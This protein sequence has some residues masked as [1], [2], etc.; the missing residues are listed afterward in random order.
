MR[1]TLVKFY[2]C[3]QDVQGVGTQEDQGISNDD[4][5][6]SD[7]F[8]TF[9]LDGAQVEGEAIV[10][11]IAGG[12]INDTF[13]VSVS[14]PFPREAINEAVEKCFRLCVGGN[15]AM[16]DITG[17]TN[18]RMSNNRFDMEY[19]VELPVQEGTYSSGAW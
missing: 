19:T 1:T 5:M 8:Y 11:Q 14:G 10:K 13:E 12:N 18:V 9:E 4:Y 7:V 6:L 16:L 2:R 15:S 3:I 17:A